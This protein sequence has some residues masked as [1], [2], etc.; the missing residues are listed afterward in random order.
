MLTE[1]EISKEIE[2]RNDVIYKSLTP[3]DG[4]GHF[5]DFDEIKMDMDSICSILFHIDSVDWSPE[6]KTELMKTIVQ[7]FIQFLLTYIENNSI[8][9]YYNLDDYKIFRSIYP[10]WCK[11]RLSRYHNMEIRNI[12]DK[13][14][15]SKLKKLSEM[16]PNITVKQCE[17]SPILDIYKDMNNTNKKVVVISRDPHMLCLLAYKDISIFNGRYFVNRNNYFMEK[18]YPA[19][20]HALIPAYFMIAGIKRNEYSGLPKYG[21]KKTDKLINENKIDIIKQTL[22]ELESI[23]KYRKIFYLNEL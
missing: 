20:H 9:V 21:K 6:Q 5:L 23:N 16:K 7:T 17:D 10:E 13:I 8:T 22:P 1:E 3:Y 11:E 2:W 4:S 14:V 18:E 19:V 15:I 12:V